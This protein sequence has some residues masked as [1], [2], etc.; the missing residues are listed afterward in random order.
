MVT[1]EMINEA[2]RDVMDPEVQ[3]NIVDLGLIREVRVEEDQ[4][5][6]KMVLTVPGC[7]LARYLFWKVQEKVEA[8]SE[9]KR[10]TV[11]LLDEPWVPPWMERLVEG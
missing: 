10:V 2:L 5:Q 9:G 3:M 1:P 6:I 7:P 8:V 4:I 11:E